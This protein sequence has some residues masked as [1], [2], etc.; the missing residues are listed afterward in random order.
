MKLELFVE[1]GTS[2]KD[3]FNVNMYIIINISRNR[4]YCTSIKAMLIIPYRVS[5]YNDISFDIIFTREKV[6]DHGSITLY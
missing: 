2:R 4:N 5:K 3:Q 6:F 1:T